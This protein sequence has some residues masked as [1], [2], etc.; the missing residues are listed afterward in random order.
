VP[1]TVMKNC[2]F[3]QFFFIKFSLKLVLTNAAGRAQM[4]RPVFREIRQLWNF[5]QKKC[6][7]AQ[8]YPIPIMR[9]GRG[10]QAWPVLP[11]GNPIW[12]FFARKSGLAYASEFPTNALPHLFPCRSVFLAISPHFSCKTALFLEF[13]IKFCY[14]TK[15]NVK[16]IK[17]LWKISQ[18]SAK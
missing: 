3:W 10:R 18:I 13:S 6:F 17:K 12:L 5:S 2:R 9:S 14:N 1:K 16:F 8:A 4:A 7:C 11:A 15:K